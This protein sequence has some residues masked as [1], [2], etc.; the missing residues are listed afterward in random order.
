MQGALNA[1]QYGFQMLGTVHDELITMVDD[2]SNLGPSQL[3]E[4]M[5]SRQSWY[6]DLPMNAEALDMLRYGSH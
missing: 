6:T 1:E 5:L 4:A 3:S 2:H